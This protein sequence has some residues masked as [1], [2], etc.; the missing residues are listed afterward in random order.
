MGK[1]RGGR[2]AL[3]KTPA[4][5]GSARGG[6]ITALDPKSIARQVSRQVRSQTKEIVE[7][8]VRTTISSLRNTDWLGPQQPV[9]PQAPVDASADIRLWDYPVGY[10]LNWQPR[11][12]TPFSFAQ[13]RWLSDNLDLMR[14]VIER[15]KDEITGDQLELVSINEDV[16]VD[17]DPDVKKIKEF[18]RWPDGQHSFRAWERMLLE[19]MYVTDS[20]TIYPW[21]KANGEPYRFEIIDGATI[22]PLIDEAGRLPEAPDPAYMQVIQTVA[23]SKLI[24]AAVASLSVRPWAIG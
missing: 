24:K 20:A 15:R 7:S 19:E 22:T 16:D 17:D 5:D 12:Y 11:K 9:P 4:V 23:S 14:E 13:L 3:S 2:G 1:Q 21:L 18:F 10:N 8:T 6:K